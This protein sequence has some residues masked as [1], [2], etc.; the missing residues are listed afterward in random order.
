MKKF[1]ALVLFFVSVAGTLFAAGTAL[2]V[3]GSDFQGKTH[4]ESSAIVA[5]ILSQIKKDYPRADGFLFCGDYTLDINNP[6]SSEAGIAALKK[7][8]S[9]SE[10]SFPPEATVLVQGNH[11]PE[12]TRGMSPSGG[13]DP[14][15]GRWG[16]F[17][18][19]EDDFMWFQGLRRTN[20]NPH[21]S[22]DESTVESTAMN[23]I[24]YLQQKKLED[25]KGPIFVISHLPLH[26]SMRTY[27]DGDAQYARLIFDV[28]NLYA[29]Q[30]LKII[31]LF[32]HNHS[33]G[34]DNYIGSARVCLL[35][36]EKMPIAACI[37]ENLDQRNAKV[38]ER[39]YDHKRCDILPLH[40][41]YMN[42]GY[43]GYFKTTDANDGADRTLSM[44]TF[45][46]G[47][48]GKVKIRRYSANGPCD[49]KAPGV[50]NTR[51]GGQEAKLNF[52]KPYTDKKTV[53]E[54]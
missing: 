5:S 7:T 22:D 33:N 42:A 2:V 17:V 23:L 50:V 11:D 32:G 34:W 6:R 36:G 29:R 16:V 13:N 26:Y 14:A 40:F 39:H 35:P 24:I 25:F 8:L 37:E 47:G 9:A 20:G 18:I 31:Y 53:C 19:N 28:L 10:M 51:D 1:L 15:N 48:N 41:V 4:E 3:A 27:N 12:D 43:T 49:L 30:G 44:T 52:Y 54:I 46:I 38:R 45:E 21:I